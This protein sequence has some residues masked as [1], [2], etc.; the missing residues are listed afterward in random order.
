MAQKRVAVVGAGAAGLAACRRLRDAGLSVKVLEKS[1]HVGGVW[2]YSPEGVVYK[3]LVTNLPKEIM[4]FP[5]HPFDPALPVR[6]SPLPSFPPTA[7]FHT[8]L[9]SSLLRQHAAC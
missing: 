4:A 3:S 7:S 2:K 8:P 6:P 5:D 9:P 1:G